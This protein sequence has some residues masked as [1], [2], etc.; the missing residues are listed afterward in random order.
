MEIIFNR[1]WKVKSK[2]KIF[3]EIQITKKTVSKDIPRSIFSKKLGLGEISRFDSHPGLIVIKRSPI[4]TII[5]T[6]VGG[7]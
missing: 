6:T 3:L 4:V 5:V 1:L 2:Q 7:Y